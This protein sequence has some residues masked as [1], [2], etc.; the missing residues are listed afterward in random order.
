MQII[1]ILIFDIQETARIKI[2]FI[3]IVN[4]TQEALCHEKPI[5]KKGLKAQLVK[6]RFCVDTICHLHC[7]ESVF[8][9]I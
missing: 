5:E 3:F 4:E 6:K 9:I 8:G 1:E 7:T 2:T